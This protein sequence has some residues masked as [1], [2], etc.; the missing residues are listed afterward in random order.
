MGVNMGASGAGIR[1]CFIV[2]VFWCMEGGK[3]HLISLFMGGGDG[4]AAVRS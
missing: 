3:W 2:F 1:K 4:I